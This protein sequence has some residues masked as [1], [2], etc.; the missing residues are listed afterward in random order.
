MEG[1]VSVDQV[2]ATGSGGDFRQGRRANEAIVDASAE[3]EIIPHQGVHAIDRDELLRDGVADAMM[4]GRGADNAVYDFATEEQHTTPPAHS[5]NT[6]T[7]LFN[8]PAVMPMPPC[9]PIDDD[10][11]DEDEGDD[12]EEQYEEEAVFRPRKLRC[13][14]YDHRLMPTPSAIM[15][16]RQAVAVAGR[17][18][19][20]WRRGNARSLRRLEQVRFKLL[21]IENSVS[22]WTGSPRDG[23][24]SAACLSAE[25]EFS[26]PQTHRNSFEPT[27]PSTKA[28][29]TP[30]LPSGKASSV[31]SA[32]A[33]S[34]PR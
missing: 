11:K 20:R 9:D 31:P 29:A 28:E 2:G 33:F 7:S 21:T 4:I 8:S 10:D 23:G 32:S 5:G 6:N 30:P 26:R 25:I 22:H 16:H 14:T 15:Y 24:E 1:N 19:W 27:R 13:C 34:P 17:W 12:D 18:R 3:R